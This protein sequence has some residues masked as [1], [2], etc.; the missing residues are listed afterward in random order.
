MLLLNYILRL[1][2]NFDILIHCLITTWTTRAQDRAVLIVWS[3]IPFIWASPSETKRRIYPLQ[4]M[5]NLVVGEEWWQNLALL[6]LYPRPCGGIPSVGCPSAGAAFPPALSLRHWG[7][8]RLVPTWRAQDPSLQTAA[9]VGDKTLQ[10]LLHP[11]ACWL[12]N[13]SFGSN[14]E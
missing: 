12:T 1:I 4:I 10:P 9:T 6:L 7:S 14:W 11:K 2:Q 5:K 13:H 8:A 3:E